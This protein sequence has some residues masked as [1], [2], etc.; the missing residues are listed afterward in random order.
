[1][2]AIALPNTIYKAH[3]G[4]AQY[5]FVTEENG[6]IIR[7]T[8]SGKLAH[9]TGRRWTQF[10]MEFHDIDGAIQQAMMLKPVNLKLH[11]G[12]N[13]H[14]SVTEKVPVID[15]RRW[16]I[17]E[18]DSTL[19]PS[20]VGIAL[21]YTQW[22]N[23]KKAVEEVQTEVP[24]LIAISPCWHDSQIDVE[25]CEECTQSPLIDYSK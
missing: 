2:A 25:R 9:F 3:I 4:G 24:Q 14:V 10:V 22:Y 23:L 15:I 19:Q 11:I 21:S 7:D 13:W 16:Y 18:V 12:G 8:T 6:V 17:C 20:S 5:I 1:M